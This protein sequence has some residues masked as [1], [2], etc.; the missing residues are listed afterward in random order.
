MSPT[1]EICPHCRVDLR[2]EPIPDESRQFYGSET[3]FSRTIGVEVHGLYDGVLFWQ[4][5]ECRGRWHR[6]PE[7]SHLRDRAEPYVEI[8]AAPPSESPAVPAPL[9]G[10]IQE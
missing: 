6:W 5:P 9:F 3:H 2:G 1:K 4:C 7:G 10:G 8:F